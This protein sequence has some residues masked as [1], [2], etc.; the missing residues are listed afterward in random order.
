MKTRNAFRDL[1]F[2]TL[3]LFYVHAWVLKSNKK[4][5][6]CTVK[7]EYKIVFILNSFLLQR[8]RARVAAMFKANM[9]WRTDILLFKSWI[10]HLL[11]ISKRRWTFLGVMIR[12]HFFQR[13]TFIVTP[14]TTPPCSYRSVII[15]DCCYQPIILFNLI[16]YNT[17]SVI[18][19]VAS[20]ISSTTQIKYNTI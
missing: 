19:K 11:S 6:S 4:L 13:Y 9:L 8:L 15:Y 2:K 20:N 18:F 3:T 16:F 17:H 10:F 12:E 7:T 5:W 1:A 14:S